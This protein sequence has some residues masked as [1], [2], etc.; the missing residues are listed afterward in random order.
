MS[1]RFL[2]PASVA[3]G[4]HSPIRHTI[5]ILSPSSVRRAYETCCCT[6]TPAAR[7][8]RRTAVRRDRATT[9]TP[10]ERNATRGAILTRD[11]L[12]NGIT[13]TVVCARRPCNVRV[14]NAG[15]R[16]LSGTGADVVWWL[17]DIRTVSA[18][19][20]HCTLSQWLVFFRS[21]CFRI[22]SAAYFW[23]LQSDS[24]FRNAFVKSGGGL[25]TKS[26]W[27]LAVYGIST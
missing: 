10:R 1:R 16:R 26:V 22:A 17:V 23:N 18:S 7:T 20:G 14:R 5:S 12:A 13:G 19:G 8:A 3:G 4:A 27:L 21:T 2:D 6:V 15:D 11:R 25:Y 9:T 24:F